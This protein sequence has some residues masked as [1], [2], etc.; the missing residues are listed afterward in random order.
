MGLSLVDFI[1]AP[2]LIIAAAYFGYAHESPPPWHKRLSAVVSSLWGGIL[3][4]GYFVMIWVFGFVMLILF[5]IIGFVLTGIGLTSEQTIELVRHGVTISLKYGVIVIAEGFIT[6]TVTKDRGWFSRES[7]NFL[8][9][10]MNGF[11]AVA[12]PICHIL[13]VLG[14]VV[15]VAHLMS[16]G[17]CL[18]F[19]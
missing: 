6:Q 17:Q 11:V 5:G 1:F 14:T 10:D 16:T 9:P 19:G 8:D 7:L 3:I 2:Y 12:K 13:M 4:F 15:D 18:L